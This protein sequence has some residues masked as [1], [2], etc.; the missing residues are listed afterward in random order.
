VSLKN[1][2]ATE[3]FKDLVFTE[4]EIQIIESVLHKMTVK[5][6]T[7][8]INAGDPVEHI[9]YIQEG[10]LRTYHLNSQGKEHTLQFAT[11]E[12]WTTD[13]TVFLYSSKAL[14]NL[15]VLQDSTI[16]RLSEKD[17]AY[18]IEQIP[19]IQ[20]FIRKRL[21]VAYAA[22]YNRVLA[23]LSQTATEQY[24]NFIAK[25]PDIERNVK[26]YHIASYLGITNESLSR[27][28]K[29]LLND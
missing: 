13:F 28:R 12:S 8:I 14:L 15:E 9:Y 26:N 6:G 5:K 3:I 19:Q 17:R 1:S 10:Y 4:Q 23:N 22:F 20:T 2:I 25:F 18:I 16:Y 7:K 21:E 24:I 29:E 27:I 11:K